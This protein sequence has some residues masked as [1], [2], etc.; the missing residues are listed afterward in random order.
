MLTFVTVTQWLH[1]LRGVAYVYS[2]ICTSE[3]FW[4]NRLFSVIFQ[5]F[6]KEHGVYITS[7]KFQSKKRVNQIGGRGVLSSNASVYNMVLLMKSTDKSKSSSNVHWWSF[8]KTHAL[9]ICRKNVI[10]CHIFL[11]IQ[12]RKLWILR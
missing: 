1:V 6:D 2:S 11:I 12:K 7:K 10:I 3:L 9:F 5:K 8:W 4:M